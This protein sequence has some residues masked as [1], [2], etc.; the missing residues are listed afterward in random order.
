MNHILFLIFFIV[1]SGLIIFSTS[2]VIYGIPFIH[3]GR[4]RFDQPA[5]TV[6]RQ[7]RALRLRT[8]SA[9]IFLTAIISLGFWHIINDSTIAYPDTRGSGGKPTYEMPYDTI[10][11]LKGKVEDTLYRP[12]QPLNPQTAVA[13]R[14]LDVAL[15]DYQNN[16]NARTYNNV[17]S[18]QNL[19]AYMAETE[20]KIPEL[21]QHVPQYIPAKRAL[22]TYVDTNEPYFMFT[23][24]PRSFKLPPW[25]YQNSW[26]NRPLWHS[27]LLWLLAGGICLMGLVFIKK[28]A[29][30]Q[31]TMLHDRQVVSQQTHSL[32]TEVTHQLR[33]HYHYYNQLLFQRI[34]NR[35][36]NKGYFFTVLC[37]RRKVN[38]P[39]R[40]NGNLHN[41]ITKCLIFTVNANGQIDS[42]LFEASFFYGDNGTVRQEINHLDRAHLIEKISYKYNDEEIN[43]LG[44]HMQITHIPLIQSSAYQKV[45]FLVDQLLQEG[46][47]GELVE[48]LQEDR[49]QEN[50]LRM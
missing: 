48:Q 18:I 5:H 49:P 22:T 50:W 20:E 17:E 27:L 24:N 12:D 19:L 2:L 36:L 6:M 29:D 26:L 16:Y 3:L 10:T 42:S 7:H 38:E 15:S 44:V 21:S 39:L 35:P 43:N 37:R 8:G 40:E 1:V 46:R 31:I 28:K 14:N 11:N 30:N 9:L 4:N 32:K 23:N 41:P 47:I 34:A 45:T 33:H 25:S 13:L